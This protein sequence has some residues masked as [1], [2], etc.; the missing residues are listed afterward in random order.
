MAKGTNP[1]R[2]RDPK[3]HKESKR[4]VSL[5]KAG[6]L[7][8]VKEILKSSLSDALT[9]D[10]LT[11]G[12]FL[13]LTHKRDIELVELFFSKGLDPNVKW[14]RFTPLGAA[15]MCG[16]PKLIELRLLSESLIQLD[17]EHHELGEFA[18]IRDFTGP[19]GS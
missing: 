15:A 4:F 12:F 14:F 2:K 3:A 16:M 6:K 10:A 7:D 8:D 18:W 5:A 9:V 1:P 19:Q 17:S 13:S 11:S